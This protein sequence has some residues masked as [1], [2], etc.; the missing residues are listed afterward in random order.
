MTLRT[1][2]QSLVM[3]GAAISLAGACTTL[4]GNDFVIETA[5]PGGGG[6]GGSTSTSSGGGT[7]GAGGGT[8]GGGATEPALPYQC[9][10]AL[11][12]H[13]RVASLQDTPND[14]WRS[15]LLIENSGHN[16]RVV[17]QRETMGAA[18]SLELYTLDEDNSHVW[19]WTSD[20]AHDIA[21]LNA[22]QIAVLYSTGGIQPPYPELFM[23][24]I[25]DSDELGS[26]STAVTLAGGQAFDD[27]DLN[28]SRF[29]AVFAP[30]QGGGTVDFFTT[31]RNNQG[32]FV[33][34]FGRRTGNSAV[35]PVLVSQGGT[36]SE[37]DTN[38]FVM[39]TRDGTSYV[40]LGD[41]ASTVGPR[42][43]VLDDSVIGPIPA[44][45]LGD[46]GELVLDVLMK[47]DT[48]NVAGA[49]IGMNVND[50]LLLM[51]DTIEPAALPTFAIA[52]LTVAAE[53][54]TVA[55]LPVGDTFMGWVADILIM[56]GGTAMAQDQLTF[57][58]FDALGRDRGTGTLP[59][60]GPLDAGEQRIAVDRV[61]VSARDEFFHTMGGNLHVVWTEDHHVGNPSESFKVMYYDQ[62]GCYPVE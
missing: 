13:V 26:N 44:R 43:Y 48:V 52:D 19:S 18:N 37:E 40:F 14:D 21:R 12:T 54:A 8:G 57:V 61:A 56:M 55:N 9:Q 60:Q 16:A 38:P 58:F 42:Q 22:N 32:T 45:S 53:Y 46:P 59:F 15:G 2:T 51:A 24:V 33:E 29:T 6:T 17:A 27:V 28:N 39:V 5:A 47:P 36:L 34:K 49:E 35:T 1:K 50:P 7:G 25:D 20:E 23:R 11:P 62:L 10:W 41:P 3:V 4:L 31:Y 30:H